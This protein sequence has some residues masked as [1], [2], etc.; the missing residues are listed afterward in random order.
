MQ[1]PL[2]EIVRLR[3]VVSPHHSLTTLFYAW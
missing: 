3:G 2:G 1:L